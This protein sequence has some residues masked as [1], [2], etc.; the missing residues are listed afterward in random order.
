M[1]YIINVSSYSSS[2]S[3]FSSSIC[4]VNKVVLKLYLLYIPCIRVALMTALPPL[5]YHLHQT[6]CLAS[7]YWE[8]ITAHTLPYKN[9]ILELPLFFISSWSLKM[10]LIGFS[11]ISVI[12]YHYCEVREK[13]NKMQQL[14]VYYQHFLNMFRAS[15][16]PSS[17]DQDMCYCTWCAAL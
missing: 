13:T 4:I 2:S 6:Y 12:N 16:C 5:S 8:L 11:E 14:D 1:W 10:G 15:L 9:I 3:S 7:H 17:G